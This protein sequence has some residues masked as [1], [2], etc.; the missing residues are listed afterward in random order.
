MQNPQYAIGDKIFIITIFI[1]LNFYFKVDFNF[2]FLCLSE[3]NLIYIT[4]LF[5]YFFNLV[6]IITFASKTCN[7]GN[8]LPPKLFLLIFQLIFQYYLS[9]I[10]NFNQFIHQ[11][12]QDLKYLFLS[13]EM[14]LSFLK[15]PCNVFQINPRHTILNK[16]LINETPTIPKFKSS[17]FQKKK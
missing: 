13:H 1:F 17:E 14:L 4:I 5:M 2:H 8:Y 12:Y 3:Q 15:F 10:Q 7:S 9:F 16:F 11:K 6:I